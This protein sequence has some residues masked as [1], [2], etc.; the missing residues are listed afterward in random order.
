MGE[1]DT[2]SAWDFPNAA[3][4]PGSSIYYSIRFAPPPIRDDLAALFGWRHAIRAVL[5]EV[6]DPGVAA[7]KLDWWRSE[8]AR[9]DDGEARHPLSK[10]LAPVIERAG[11]PRE[12]F[13]EVIQVQAGVLARAFPKDQ[14]A[15]VASAEADLGSI[16]ELVA[17]CFGCSDPADLASAR[18]AGTYCALVDRLRDS[19]WLL[20]RGRLGILPSDQLAAA[21]L[22]PERL[23]GPD[24]RAAL[25]GML[26]AAGA[27]VAAFGAASVKDAARLPVTLRIHQ[28]LQRLLLD[29]LAASGFDV[30]GQ[31]IALTP[32][33]KL[34]HAWRE[35][36]GA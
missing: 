6:T 23:S 28:R 17:R 27:Q 22:I 19:G 8:L 30:L 16:A 12:P 33:R 34:W 10:C 29:E 25:P 3:T 20:R 26:S 24:G 21:D 9:I 1:R 32:M 2:P 5:D 13:L 18:R 31:R 11:L 7:A 4:P 14:A 35:H 15:W 36:R